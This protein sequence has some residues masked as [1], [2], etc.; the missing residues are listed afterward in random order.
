MATATTPATAAL[1]EF[2]PIAP[3]VGTREIRL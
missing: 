3:V 1:T 2:L